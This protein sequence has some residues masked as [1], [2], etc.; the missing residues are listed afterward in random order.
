MGGQ[1]PRE[2][3][4]AFIDSLPRKYILSETISGVH[5]LSI[6]TPPGALPVGSGTDHLELAQTPESHKTPKAQSHKTAD[7]RSA[8]GLWGFPRPSHF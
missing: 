5:R 6:L 4:T 8:R 1:K 2:N 7:V 3:L